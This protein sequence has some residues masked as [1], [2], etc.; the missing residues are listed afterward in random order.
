MKIR[1]IEV[2]EKI[3][4]WQN[5]I[6]KSTAEEMAN[7]YAED[8]V[9]IPTFDN[10]MKGRKMIEGYF[11]KFLDKKNMKCR[12]TDSQTIMLDSQYNVSNGYYV[13]S[14]DDAEEPGEKEAVFARFTY[15]L[16]PQGEIITHHSSEEPDD[17][18]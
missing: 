16:N 13:F 14:F 3:L 2:P 8:A 9:L 4:A 5:A 15:V 17:V 10:I 18:D 11:K 7:L 6:G 1:T 12:I